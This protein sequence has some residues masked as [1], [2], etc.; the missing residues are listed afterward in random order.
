MATETTD[1]S[2]LAD[3]TRSGDAA[4][5]RR[6]KCQ[7]TRQVIVPIGTWSSMKCAKNP[8]PY[9]NA[10]AIR[11]PRRGLRSERRP[12][13]P[14]EN[15]QGRK[16]CCNRN[17][18]RRCLLT[19]KKEN[20]QRSRIHFKVHTFASKAITASQPSCS[21]EDHVDLALRCRAPRKGE[22]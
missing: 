14:Q 7:P 12:T 22:P 1:R 13:L 11:K 15:P 6:S 3:A 9:P 10:E 16:E 8:K 5:A 21:L 19:D 4:T 17:K 20:H 18:S 2:D